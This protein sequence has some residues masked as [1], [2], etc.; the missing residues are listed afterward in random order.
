M[1]PQSDARIAF[2]ISFEA[3]DRY[4]SRLVM[5]LQPRWLKEA[6]SLN[7]AIID[8]N[9]RFSRNAS[10]YMVFWEAHKSGKYHCAFL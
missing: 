7:D 9:D 4:L 6:D 8:Y 10:A 1:Q 5:A 3:P 2:R